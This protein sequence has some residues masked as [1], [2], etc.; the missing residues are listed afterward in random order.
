MMSW[1]N[2]LWFVGIFFLGMLAG[3]GMGNL[4][5]S[6]SYNAQLE[7]KVTELQNRFQTANDNYL[8]LA[9]EYNKLFTLRAPVA[10]NSGA[11]APAAP[12]APVVAS[13]AAPKVTTAPADVKTPPTA[14]KPVATPAVKA[15]VPPTAAPAA[16][17]PKAE[18][19]ALAIDGTGPL[20][21]APPLLVRFTDLSTGNITS[22]KWEFGDGETSSEKNPEHLY[23]TCP[24]EKNLC[25]VKLTVCGA[26][27]C[28]TATKPDYLWVSES[29]TGC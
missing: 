20:E 19:K 29:C 9:R 6:N 11:P 13:P 1:K 24:G 16:S 21:G 2:I 10:S 17:K 7:Q 22:W 27:G 18:F 5:G 25:T 28:T 15:T 8:T 3:F 4:Y 14:T 12:V 23:R 26:D